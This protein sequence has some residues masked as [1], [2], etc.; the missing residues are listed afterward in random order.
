MSLTNK[1]C[2]CFSSWSYFWK[3]IL[4]ILIFVAL[5]QNIG[6]LW[7]FSWNYN[8]NNFHP[9]DPEPASNL[10]Y[11]DISTCSLTNVSDRDPITLFQ[12]PYIFLPFISIPLINP[13]S[14]Y[15]TT[16]FHFLRKKK[17]VENYENADAVWALALQEGTAGARLDI[18]GYIGIQPFSI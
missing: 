8:R 15:Y 12:F 3:H 18:M 1:K 2:I 10:L 13:H 9:C 17:T 7:K 16:L 14:I 5:P 6:P 11:Q 4:R